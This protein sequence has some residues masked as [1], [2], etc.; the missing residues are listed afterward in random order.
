MFI[1]VEVVGLILNHKANQI[2]RK[3]CDLLAQTQQRQLFGFGFQHDVKGAEISNP[4]GLDELDKGE[5]VDKV[6]VLVR[7]GHGEAALAVLIEVAQLGARRA[8]VDLGLLVGWPG[9]QGQP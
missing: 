4:R 5:G 1:G 9:G 3:F 7:Q 8:I 2:R 6:A